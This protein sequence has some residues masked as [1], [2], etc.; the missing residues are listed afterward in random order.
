MTK[1]NDVAPDNAIEIINVSKVYK[2]PTNRK[3]LKYNSSAKALQNITLSVKKGEIFGIVG[4][5]GAGKSTLLNLCIGLER[6]TSGEINMFGN[7]ITAMHKKQLLKLRRNIGFVAQGESL[8]NNLSVVQNVSMPLKIKGDS[9]LSYVQ[10]VIDFVGLTDRLHHY[11]AT[12]SGGQRQRVAIARALASNPKII[13][14]DEPTSALDSSTRDDILR[15]ISEARKQFDMTCMIVSH[16]IDAVKAVCDR[17][18]LIEK[19]QML[20]V[21]SVNPLQTDKSMPYLDQV[22]KYLSE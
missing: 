15:L 2:N 14:F 1:V 18:A 5:S 11:P 7:E 10:E 3:Q 16:E 8:L 4:E 17:A 13:L 20:E 12:L 21:V 22:R 19:G 9:D 6:P